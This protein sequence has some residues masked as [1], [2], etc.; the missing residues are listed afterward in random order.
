VVTPPAAPPPAGAPLALRHE[1]ARKGIHLATATIPVAYAAGLPRAWLLW[2]LTAL[3]AAAVA[4]ELGRGRHERTRALV[5]RAAGRLFREHERERWSGATWLAVALLAAAL[6][7][8]RDVAVAT[9]WAVS[10]GDA[11]AAV[12]GRTLGRRASRGAG[13]SLAGSLACAG[14][15]AVGALLV[16]RLPP[17]ES[18]TAAAV[19]ALAERPRAPFDDNIRIVLA[20]GGSLLLL[21]ALGV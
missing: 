2:L 14:A 15:A 16:A 8:P 11:A 1:L 9:M 7:F 20:V 18:L 19:A 5:E 4:A 13:K 21:R 17:V 6:L 10:V 12:V 3:C